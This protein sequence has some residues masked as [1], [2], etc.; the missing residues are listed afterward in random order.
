MEVDEKY[1]RRCLELAAK[2]RGNVKPNPMVGAVIVHNSGQV[3]G[4]GFHRQYGCAHAEVNAITAVEEESMLRQ[5]TLYVNLEPCS[6][7]GKTP[8]CADLIIRKGIPRV[9][10][11]CLDPFP[12]VSGRGIKKLRDAGVEVITGIMEKEAHNLNRIFMTA[13]TQQRP[14]IIL[15]WAQSADGFIDK[16]RKNT[17]EPP[18]HLSSPRTQQLAHKLRTEVS[19][20]MVGTNTAILDNPS[21]TARNWAGETPV[22]VAIDR[23]LRIPTGYHLLDGSYPTIIFTEECAEDKENVEYI[24]I[25]FEED[26]IPGILNHLYRRNLTSLLVEGGATLHNYFLNADVWDEIR[27]ETASHNLCEG[28][29]A[30][31]ICYLKE[32][33]VKNVLS[34]VPPYLS[35]ETNALSFFIKQCDF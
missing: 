25:N 22:R 17:S 13:H 14:Y 23:H 19:A 3:I 32:G 28:V 2:G 34:S 20:I 33:K 24:R 4:E 30:P 11:A 6:H 8:P 35:G 21:L 15:K 31:D 26:I 29:A 10:V 9:V 18:V 27:V 7:Y 12:E 1:M 5:S 16:I